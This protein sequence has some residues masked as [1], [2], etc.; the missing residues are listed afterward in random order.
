MG[1]IPRAGALQAQHPDD[2]IRPDLATF[3]VG[4]LG[5]IH[6][7]LSNEIQKYDISKKEADKIIS[8]MVVAAIRGSYKVW[9]SRCKEKWN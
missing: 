1:G 2:V 4:S 9:V 3:V 6:P 7:E 5:V 8:R